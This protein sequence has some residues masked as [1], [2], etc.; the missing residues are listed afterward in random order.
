[1]EYYVFPQ[2]AV[3]SLVFSIDNFWKHS[4]AQWEMEYYVFPQTAVFSLIFKL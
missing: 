3:F 1:M 4:K 2:T